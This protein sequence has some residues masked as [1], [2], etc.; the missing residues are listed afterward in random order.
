MA[1]V[2]IWVGIQDIPPQIPTL[3]VDRMALLSS[4]SRAPLCR[5]PRPTKWLFR[6]PLSRSETTTKVSP[7]A[8]QLA[9]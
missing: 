8:S 1:K 3:H 5:A 9:N 7:S 4:F 2:G 6:T